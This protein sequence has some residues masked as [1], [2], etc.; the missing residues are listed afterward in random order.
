MEQS[1]ATPLTTISTN[2]IPADPWCDE[3]EPKIVNFES[4]SAAAYRIAGGIVRT[5]CD[6]SRKDFPINWDETICVF[7][8]AE[9]RSIIH[10]NL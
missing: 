7:I 8:I 3:N 4:I 2:E 9:T 1:V 10:Y 6:V 5:P